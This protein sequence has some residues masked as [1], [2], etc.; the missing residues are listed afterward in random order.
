MKRTP[1]HYNASKFTCYCDG[2]TKPP[3]KAHP[4]I[5]EMVVPPRSTRKRSIP[6][7]N[8]TRCAG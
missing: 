4:L 2:T 7:H 8:R 1:R 5:A 6:H 3:H